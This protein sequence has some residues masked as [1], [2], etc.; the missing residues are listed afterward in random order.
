MMARLESARYMDYDY[1]NECIFGF[2][3]DGD[4]ELDHVMIFGVCSNA[5]A[6]KLCPMQLNV[7]LIG[8]AQWRKPRPELLAKF[9]PAP[10]PAP[11]APLPP[12]SLYTESPVSAVSANSHISDEGDF[13]DVKGSDARLR[14]CS[15]D[16]YTQPHLC[17]LDT[18]MRE[19]APNGLCYAAF[20]CRVVPQHTTAVWRLILHGR[21]SMVLGF[22]EHY[23]D[24]S[25]AAMADIFGNEAQNGNGPNGRVMEVRYDGKHGTLTVRNINT[26]SALRG[27]HR[28][29]VRGV[30]VARAYRLCVLLNAPGTITMF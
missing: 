26:D 22:G 9:T 13:F 23:V 5:E 24:C 7:E 16:G 15:S 20:G 17:K 10:A 14:L 11:A 8:D 4:E 19:A 2:D 12:P 27:R 29:A 28:V 21:S 6:K 18:V 30:D 1:D 25:T 3:A